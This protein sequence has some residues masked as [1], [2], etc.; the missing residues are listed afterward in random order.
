M[1]EGHT[2]ARRGEPAMTSLATPEFAGLI[3]QLYVARRDGLG[4]EQEPAPDLD[5]D[6]ALSVQLAVLARFRQQNRGLG[7][8]KAAL[9]SG[10]SRDL[11]GKDFRPF[12]YVLKDRVFASGA[13]VRIAGI[14]RC[15][16]EPELCVILGSPLRGAD[17]DV[18]DARAAVRGIAPAFEIN[19]LRVASGLSRTLLLADGLAQWGIVVGSETAVGSSLAQTRVVLSRDNETLADVTPGAA[20][21]DPFLSL[22]RMCHVLDRY[23]LGLE[24]GQP[25]I[26]GSF[27][28]QDID[29]PGVYRA[30]FSGVGT[31]EIVF[32]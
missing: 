32:E 5:V 13:H 20:M 29:R 17:V 25:V 19:E 8:W 6:A 7:G 16:I 9:S 15:K 21:D 26:T 10:R 11:L 24:P 1:D 18:A 23:G 22:A 14:H 4:I 12:G 30:S 3:E 2:A 27:C 28:H 31:V